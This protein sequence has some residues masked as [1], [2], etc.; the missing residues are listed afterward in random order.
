MI[1]RFVKDYKDY[2]RGEVINVTKQEGL[3]LI[4]KRIAKADKMMTQMEIK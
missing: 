2:A 3:H 1:V 4:K